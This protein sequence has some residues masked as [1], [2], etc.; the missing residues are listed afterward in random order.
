MK[1][2]HC[3]LPP[4]TPERFDLDWI[5][6]WLRR[7][8][9]LGLVEAELDPAGK[10]HGRQQAPALVADRSGD[11]DPLGLEGGHDG[12][13]VVGHE[14]ELGRW[15]YCFLNPGHC[16]LAAWETPTA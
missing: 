12:G 10:G 1:V 14:I 6:R 7:G 13:D 16:G 15:Q 2:L 8:R 4:S 3:L 9:V 5:D 11:L